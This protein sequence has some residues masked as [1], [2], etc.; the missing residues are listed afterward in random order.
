LKKY[1]PYLL[2]GLVILAVILLAIISNSNSNRKLNER[3]T[4]LQRD[5]IPYGTFVAYQNLPQLFPKASVF[6]TRDEPAEWDSLSFVD[7]K[8]AL[9]I[10]CPEFNATSYEMKNLI[11]FAENGN[12]VFV[13]T[14]NLSWDVI[15]LLD[16]AIQ[17][18]RQLLFFSSFNQDTLTVSLANPPYDSL[19]SYTYPGKQYDGYFSRIDTTITTVIGYDHKGRADF[20][21]FKAGKGNLYVHLAP[22]AFTNYF[23]L[24]KN[25]FPY[26]EKAFSLISPDTKRIAWDE[27]FAYK[28][29]PENSQEPKPRNWLAALLG[30][31]NPD[32][33]PVF[34]YAFWI[35]LLLLVLYVLMEMRRKQRHIPIMKKPTNESLDFVKTIGRLYHDKGDHHNLARKMAAYFLEHVRNR[36]KLPTNTLNEEFVK[37]LQAKT[38]AREEEIRPI[39]DFIGHLETSV[40]ISARQLAAFHKQLESFYK[41]A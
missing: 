10:V 20:I 4:L 14:M 1:I 27:Y 21:R 8:Q 6:I 36:Y 24:H 37:S 25:N 7:D 5:K 9:I 2:G 26:Y 35:L 18:S 41:K 12:D 23:L 32:D 19:Y 3:V 30:L 13:S 22:M 11:K 15:Q 29:Q 39:V 16:C 33:K 38:G 17:T 31:K 40:F 28:P 34:Q